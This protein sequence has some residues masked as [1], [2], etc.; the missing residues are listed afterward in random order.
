MKLLKRTLLIKT[1]VLGISILILSSCSSSPESLKVI[2]EDTNMVSVVD[3][4]SI[5]KKGKLEEISNFNFFKTVKK[6]VRNENK[7]VSKIIDNVIEDPTS[8]GVN[9]TKDLFMFYV[10]EA[11]DEQFFCMSVDLQNEET[12]VTFLE[13]VLDDSAMSYSIEKEKGYKYTIL[14]G[15]AAIAWDMNKAVFLVAK[16]RSSRKNLDLEVEMLF[17]LEAKD[18]ITA[19]EEFKT[20]YTNKKDVSFWCSTNLFEDNYYFKSVEKELDFEITNNYLAAFLDFGSD[21]MSL[22]GTVTPNNEI[23]KMMEENN[24]WTTSFN[25]QTLSYLPQKSYANASI[26]L[27]PVAYYNLL[28]EEE[29]F[30]E[31]EKKFNKQM[32]FSL[33]EIVSS[34]KG[35]AVFS[36]GGFRQKE[37]TSYNRYYDK[38]TKETTVPVMGLVFD[39]NTDD[40][41]KKMMRKIPE[42]QLEKRNDYYELKVDKKFSTYL[43][44]NNEMCLI[45]NDK[46]SVKS[47]KNGGY[48]TNSLKD[49]DF[50]SNFTESGYY[51]FLNLNYNDYPIEVKKEFKDIQS[52]QEEK[53]FGIWNEF[54]RSIEVKQ[55]DNYSVEFKLT[56]SNKGNNSLNT[57]ISILDD[58]YKEFMS[59]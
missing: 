28:K 24:I 55:I 8:T 32:D 9:F 34:F 12:F 59:L 7:K 56:T 2:P 22:T 3:I 57:L 17:D 4:Y 27:D 38:V 26:S 53:L 30:T 10:D 44:F 48:E 19:K 29:D 50:V 37:V 41:L 18:Q 51:S 46:T 15:K 47:F 52:N 35:N 45:T 40:I 5:I 54:A 42:N 23:E 13:S 16:N 6:E 31:I 20:F 11:K 49:S 1:I 14:S 21:Y 36:L 25:T 43:A 58:N 39:L 33:K